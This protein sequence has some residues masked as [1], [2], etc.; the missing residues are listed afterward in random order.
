[1][2]SRSHSDETEYEHVETDDEDD[3]DIEFS[4]KTKLN[5]APDSDIYVASDDDDTANLLPKKRC[6]VSH[7][8]PKD[9]V[10]MSMLGALVAVILYL[11]VCFGMNIWVN[12]SNRRV[13]VLFGDSLI[14]RPCQAHALGYS[15][16]NDLYTRESDFYPEIVCAGTSGAPIAELREKM[17]ADVLSRFNYASPFTFQRAGPP[18]AVVLYWDSDINSGSAPEDP[19]SDEAVDA[20]LS[21]LYYVIERLQKND[22]VVILAGPTLSGELP[23]GENE[24]DEYLNYYVQLNNETAVKYNITYLDTRSMYY[25]A[26]PEGWD[27]TSGYL[28]EDGEHPNGRGAAVLRRAFRDALI[29][30]DIF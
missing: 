26:L 9:V 1:M 14:A 28:T 8:C 10:H 29:A 12:M 2:R 11:I 17:N 3:V 16:N 5:D 18:V 24:L 21:N 23:D 25:A 6:A 27:E 13:V 22:V 15:L 19:N 30:S 20:Y 7:M 4:L